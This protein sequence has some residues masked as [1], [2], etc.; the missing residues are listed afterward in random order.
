[1]IEKKTY[2]LFSSVQHYEWGTKGKNAYIPNLLGIDP[3]DKPYAELWIGAHST[4]P[5]KI[6]IEYKLIELNKL[7][8]K[9]PNEILGER[10]SKQFNKKLPF[11]LKVLS[12]GQALSIQTHPNKEQ[13]EKLNQKDPKNY[14]DDNHKPEIA[15]VL[16]TL[17]TLVG[18]KNPNEILDNLNKYPPLK[19]FLGE[20]TVSVFE[21]SLQ[22]KDNSL[23]NIRNTFSKL[24]KNSSDVSALSNC[25]NS[26][27]QIISK[28]TDLDETEKLFLELKSDYGIDIGLLTL[29]F[30]KNL[31]LVE[32]EA[33]FT[34][35]GVPHA[36]LKGDIV[37]CMANS[38]N[39]VRAGLTP[40]FKDVETL[41]NILSYED[42][43]PII[44][45]HYS[46]E[47]MTKY[48]PPI[49]EFQIEKI[50]LDNNGIELFTKDQVEILLVI[51]GEVNISIDNGSNGILTYTKGEAIM[52]P[53]LVDQ[54][55]IYTETTAIV[56]RVTIP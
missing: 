49:D 20:E 51:K 43:D 24:I 18:F 26:I 50:E 31:Q 22:N 37:E 17:N 52:I 8:E 54:Y 27:V 3:E 10:V 48:S 25:I 29:F 14:P 13:A 32:G 7:I 44:T 39:V 19:E 12:A 6:M 40:K 45:G 55:K 46:N 28:K 34:P 16:T 11:L 56:Y 23:D 30:L 35:A 5:S 2:Q 9:F 38:D 47:V 21:L 41:L 42:N 1:M 15:I 53:A 4:L 33:I 36:Y